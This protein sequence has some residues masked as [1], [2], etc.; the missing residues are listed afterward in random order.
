LIDKVYGTADEQ[1]MASL[2]DTIAELQTEGDVEVVE[3]TEEDMSQAALA[4]PRWKT[5]RSSS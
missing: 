5:R 2:M 4:A 1:Q 3:E